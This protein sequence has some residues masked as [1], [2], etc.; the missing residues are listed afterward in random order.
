GTSGVAG[1][2]DLNGN[3]HMAYWASTNH[4]LHRIY[5]YDSGTNTLNS[6][7]SFF[8]VDTAGSANHPS[9]AISPFYNSLTVARVSEA[10]NPPKIR[11]RT[12]TSNGTWG[13][14]QS[15]S[16]ASVWTSTANGINIDQGPSLI[17]DSTGLKYMTYIQSFDGSVG[18][19]GRIHYVTDTGSGW[20]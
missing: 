4:I 15:A 1:M 13:G 2:V 20:I 3:L 18:D 9:I 8:Q 17:I 11:T 12:R 16:T 6:L 19:Y 7:S 10:D 5:A 14:I